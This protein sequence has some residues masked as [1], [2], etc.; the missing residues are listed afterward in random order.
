MMFKTHMAFALL[1]AY[2]SY[3]YFPEANFWIFCL[4]IL[5]G[6]SL[7]DIDNKR[8]KISHKAK[9]I[10]KLINPLTKH[11]G[12]FHSIFIPIG[13]YFLLDA[14]LGG[15]YGLALSL[16]YLSHLVIDGM[17]PLGVNFLHPITTLHLR[18]PIETNSIIEKVLLGSLILVIIIINI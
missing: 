12:I 16:G 18:G 15:Y 6:A 5:F 7:P 9:L 13:L 3:H 10:N 8:S 17:T 14:I 4:L 1:V 2:T 11:R